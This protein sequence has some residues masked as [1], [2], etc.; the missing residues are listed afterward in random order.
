M[1]A[2]DLAAV[3]DIRSGHLWS[4]CTLSATVE[5]TPSLR[6]QF[7]RN[8]AR[9]LPSCLLCNANASEVGEGPLFALIPC[10][11]W[12]EMKLTIRSADIIQDKPFAIIKRTSEF[13]RQHEN[14]KVEVA[15]ARAQ[16][17]LLADAVDAQVS[18][19]CFKERYIASHQTDTIKI[20][21]RVW[22]L[23]N[24]VRGGRSA[25]LSAEDARPVAP[26]P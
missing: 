4:R 3:C 25:H 10:G 6:L 11:Q 1:T 21:R 5:F 20:R 17:A 16:V 12:L 23:Q 14:V 19:I 2:N 18:A 8:S 7:I 13:H 22:V 15:K 26:N 9:M 24:R